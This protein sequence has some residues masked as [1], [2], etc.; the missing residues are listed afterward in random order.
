MTAAERTDTRPQVDVV[1]PCYNYGRYL[2]QSVESVLFQEG[3]EVR[4]L[5]IDDA[6]SDDTAIVAVAL[7]DEDPRVTFVRHHANKGH[8]ETYNE[9]IE[10]TSG[11]Y[12]LLLSADDYLLPG[13]LQRATTLMQDHPGIGFTF[14]NVIE[15]SD[16]ER[17]SR[18]M[19]AAGDA[20]VVVFDGLDFIE[21]SGVDNQVATCSAVVRTKLQKSLGGYRGDLPHAGDMEMWLRFAAHGSVGFISECQGVYRRHNSNMSAQYYC[22]VGGSTVYTDSGRLADL[23]Q[24]K[25]VFDRFFED[26]HDVVPPFEYLRRQKQRQL[27]QATLQH[28]SASFNECRMAESQQLSDLALTIWPAVNRSPAWLRLACKRWMGI[29]AWNALKKALDAIRFGLLHKGEV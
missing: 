10:W 26:H 2:R 12:M 14:G 9:G 11:D 7:A 17:I 28:A 13:A 23:M 8:I 29:R 15:L 6:S 19:T 16:R 3:V 1:I 5:V 4:V 18:T 20:E 24:R 27:A 21:K 22:I 25:S